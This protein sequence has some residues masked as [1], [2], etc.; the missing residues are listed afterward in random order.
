MKEKEFGLTIDLK[1]GKAAAR[2]VTCDF[3]YAYVKI[4]AE[5]TT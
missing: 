5:Y 3:S 1:L 2:I 4:N